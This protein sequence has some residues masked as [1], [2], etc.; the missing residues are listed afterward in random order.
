MTA[1]KP[2]L[3]LCLLAPLIAVLLA[4]P[5]HAATYTCVTTAFRGNK[6]ICKDDPDVCTFVFTVNEKTK[7]MTRR[8]SEE[9]P[10]VPVTVDKWEDNKIIAHED[11]NRV[12]SRFIEQYYYKIGLENGEFLMANEYMTNSGRY[13]T[14][15]E[16]NM[17]DPKKY[18]RWFKPRLF[19]ETGSCRFK[20]KDRN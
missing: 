2:L 18:A 6:W 20:G 16:L 9:Q 15:E 3:Q 1:P 13:L 4:M 5:V 14:Q 7:V 8:A 11:R 10:V 12:D 19:T 17:A